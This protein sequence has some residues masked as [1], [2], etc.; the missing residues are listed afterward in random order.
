MKLSWIHAVDYRDGSN[1]FT[2]HAA[3]WLYIY[4]SRHGKIADHQHYQVRCKS[5]DSVHL[6]EH[7]GKPQLPDEQDSE[8]KDSQIS[9]DIIVLL[10]Y[11]MISYDIV[12]LLMYH[13]ISADH[14]RD[15]Q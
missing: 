6:A 7:Q 3:T 14:K 9:Y 15:K 8:T 11:Y 2:E 10:M 4:R 13:M 1:F 5:L 12:M